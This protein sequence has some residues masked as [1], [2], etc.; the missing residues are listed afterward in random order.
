MFERTGA[1]W[2]STGDKQKR[3]NGERDIYLKENLVSRVTLWLSQFMTI[4]LSS[5]RGNMH[6][7]S[8]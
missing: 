7:G 4:M 5:F 3:V 8:F 6:F 2:E 1:V